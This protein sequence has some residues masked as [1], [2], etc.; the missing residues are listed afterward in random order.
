[1]ADGSAEGRMSLTASQMLALQQP[2]FGEA[3]LP[4]LVAKNDKQKAILNQGQLQQQKE[5]SA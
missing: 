3:P 2:F 1:M 4:C 5:K